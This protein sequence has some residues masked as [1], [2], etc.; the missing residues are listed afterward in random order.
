MS[1]QDIMAD[2][3]ETATDD[4]QNTGQNAGQDTPDASQGDQND[5]GEGKGHK[6]GGD[7]LRADLVKERRSRQALEKELQRLKDRDLSELERAQRQAKEAETRLAKLEQE[8]AKH[9]VALKHELPSDLVDNITGETEDDMAV[10]AE[11]LARYAKQK[12]P[13]PDPSQG[14]RGGNAPRNMNDLIR[15]AVRR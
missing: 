2:D 8:A 15:S 10:S 13:R 9:R 12:A 14:S 5:A 11:R 1:E 4:Q 3:A 6:G 7:A